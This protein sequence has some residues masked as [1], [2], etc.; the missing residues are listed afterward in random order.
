MNPSSIATCTRQDIYQETFKPTILW[1]CSKWAVCWMNH[2]E[3]YSESNVTSSECDKM[4]TNNY[5][6]KM[7]KYSFLMSLRTVA[8][9]AKDMFG[10]MTKKRQWTLQDNTFLIFQWNSCFTS[11]TWGNLL[12]LATF[13]LAVSAFLHQWFWH[14]MKEQQLYKCWIDVCFWGWVRPLSKMFQIK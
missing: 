6:I 12:Q 7:S 11:K 4:L 9:T 14:Q 5:C 1:A 2:N 3:L 13:C 10:S 8:L